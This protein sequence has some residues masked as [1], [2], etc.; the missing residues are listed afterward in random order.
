MGLVQ[1]ATA[2]QFYFISEN[3]NSHLTKA[4]TKFCPYLEHNFLRIY[5][6]AV[7][8]K[9]VADKMKYTLYKQHTSLTTLMVFEIT[10]I[11]K[12][13]EHMGQNSYAMRKPR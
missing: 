3:N 11:T 12:K 1:L 2:W 6:N 10:T 4:Y 5:R 7:I 8:Q 13:N 9:D